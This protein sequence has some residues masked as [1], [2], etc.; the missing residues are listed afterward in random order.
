MPWLQ[1]TSLS[2]RHK[3]Q[4]QK[5]LSQLVFKPRFTTYWLE[6]LSQVSLPLEPQCSI[7][8]KTPPQNLWHSALRRMTNTSHCCQ[9]GDRR[10]KGCS[11][12]AALNTATFKELSTETILRIKLLHIH[13]CIIETLPF[14]LWIC[15]QSKGWNY[16][17]WQYY[18]CNICFKETRVKKKNLL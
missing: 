18:P 3:G 8:T 5:A 9:A 4:E 17:K 7:K 6:H 16:F 12:M 1:Q 15:R 13:L 2:D 14:F 11:L 10:V